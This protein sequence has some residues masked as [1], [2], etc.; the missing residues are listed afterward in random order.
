[1]KSISPLLLL[2][3]LAGIGCRTA[4]AE[5]GCDYVCTAHSAHRAGERDQLAACLGL[6]PRSLGEYHLFRR[7]GLGA[8]EADC[9]R[10]AA[11]LRGKVEDEIV[12]ILMRRIED[13]MGKEIYKRW[14]FDRMNVPVLFREFRCSGSGCRVSCVAAVKKDDLSPKGVIRYL[15]LEYKMD[16]L[17]K[18]K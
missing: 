10:L 4:P 6:D 3:L 11:E 2:I 16:I 9:A 13:A 15:P 7:E 8:G 1:M 17:G 18:E 14:R 5:Q 12:E